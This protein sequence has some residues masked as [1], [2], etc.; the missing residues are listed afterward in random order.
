MYVRHMYNE[1]L[2]YF[3]YLLYYDTP[4]NDVTSAKLC[5]LLILKIYAAGYWFVTA[6]Y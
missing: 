1:L 3:T 4:T 2:T 5:V 6:Y